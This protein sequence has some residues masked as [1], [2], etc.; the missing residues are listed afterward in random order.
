M[1]SYGAHVPV[2]LKEAIDGLAIRVDGLYLDATYG[3]GGHSC[4]ILKKLGPQGKL[5]AVDQD[6][7][8][9]S[10]AQQRFSSDK[11][12]TIY[13]ANFSSL[14]ALAVE[15]GFA[16][17]LDGLLLDLGV[18]SPQLDEADRG[19]SFAKDGPLDM[20]MNPDLGE[21]AASWVRRTELN[22]MKR[23]F[24][25]YGEER[26]AGRIAKA[27]IQYREE[28]DI[29][30]TLQFAEIVK[31]AHPRWE[32][33][34]HPATRV[35]QAVRIQVNGELDSLKTVLSNAQSLLK[36]GGRLSV[37]SFHSLEDRMVKRFIR[38]GFDPIV[39]PRGLPVITESTHPFRVV[40]K[41]VKPSQNEIDVNN[42][43]RSSVLRVAERCI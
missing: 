19:F 39:V 14:L 8:A 10:H 5:L 7:V 43:S 41:P 4:E 21:S 34:K 31:Q 6:P 3:R 15:E 28:K 24:K 27:I 33:G 25:E 36:L 17:Q 38:D 40:S 1:Q 18:S 13:R 2:L 29:T 20:R 32:K 37:I 23:V 30:T 16:G 22:E 11:R 12:F 42:R 35:F 9:V 26:Y